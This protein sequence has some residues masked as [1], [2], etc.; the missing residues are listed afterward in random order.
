MNSYTLAI[1]APT[2]TDNLF[3][4]LSA[5]SK[6]KTLFTLDLTNV[7]E[8]Q[9]FVADLSINWGDGSNIEYYKKDPVKNYMATSIFDELIYGKIGGSVCTQYQHVYNT[10]SSTDIIT[11]LLELAL[12]SENGYILDYFI[13]V[14]IYPESF[15]DSIKDL[16]LLTT[17]ILP[18][19]ANYTVANFEATGN[20]YS[21]ITVLSD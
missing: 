4:Q 9:F 18:T 12:Y 15:Y 20:N 7:D 5:A 1:S 8:S 17:Q 13:Q 11:Y 3:L 10:L 21:F 14:S 2:I 6:G 19:S 16:Q